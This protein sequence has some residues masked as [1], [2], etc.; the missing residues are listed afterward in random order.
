VDAGPG[1][2]AVAGPVEAGSGVLVTAGRKVSTRTLALVA[3]AVWLCLA[4]Y[5]LHWGRSW[6]LD[7]RVYRGAG[8]AWLH[9]AKPY[10]LHFTGR[11]LAF[12]YPPFALTV[13]LPLAWGPL[14]MVETI[15]WLLS[16]A[17]LVGVLT[18]ALRRTTT[19]T[20]GRS[21]AV[22]ALVGGLSAIAF[23]PLRSNM[24]YG[25]INWILMF[26]IVLD[27]T[28][29]RGR[30]RGTLVGVAAAIKLTPLVYLGYFL[31]RRQWRTAARGLTVF[32]LCNLIGAA[33]V[34]TD[35]WRFWA[36]LFTK[37]GSTGPTGF[38][39]NQS[40]LGMLYRAPFGG[41]TVALVLWIPLVLL[42][43]AAGLALARCLLQ[44][45]RE[46]EAVVALAFTELLVS[47]IS[48]THHWSWLVL[49]P[50]I[51]ARQWRRNRTVGALMALIVAVAVVAPYW[52]LRPTWIAD[53]SLVLV[54]AALLFVWTVA[55]VRAAAAASDR[56]RPTLRDGARG[57]N[58]PGA[59]PGRRGAAARPGVPR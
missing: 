37:M 40:W 53:D 49:V 17:C 38:V 48:W 23:E 30:W 18:V 57:S 3:G 27:L 5:M 22:A 36:R 54:A 26:L 24:D 6:D 13:L 55:E 59:G 28:A 16:A 33:V 43:L 19:L 56:P 41:G 32:V 25:Q 11:N 46:I 58:P 31:V 12:T 35:T 1:V 29:V 15:W 9:G 47:P 45:D 2:G 51:T 8:Q 52:W 20:G 21:V 42:T 34:G 14:R 7:L 44:S 39:S 4:G 50:L 10:L